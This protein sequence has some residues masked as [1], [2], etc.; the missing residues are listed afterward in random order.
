MADDAIPRRGFLKGA[1]GAAAATVLSGRS[2]SVQ[3]QTPATLIP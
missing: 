3:A 2:K 1:G